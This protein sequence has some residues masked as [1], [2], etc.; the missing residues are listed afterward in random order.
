[1]KLLI[2]TTDTTLQ[3]WGSFKKKMRIVDTAIN[4]GIH[5]DFDS[6][7]VKYVKVTPLVVGGRI[8]HY[9]LEKLKSPYFKQGYDIV[10]LHTSEKQWDDW[11]IQ[12]SL[13]GANPIRKTELGDFYF[14][15][16]EHSLRG[17]LN[18][19]IQVLIHEFRHEYFQQTGLPDDTHKLHGQSND[20]LPHMKTLDWSLYQPVRIGLRNTLNLL[21]KSF[22]ALLKKTVNNLVKTNGISEIH[23]LVK[24][25]SDAIIADMQTLNQPVRL[26]EGYRSPERQTELYN[27]G[28]TTV[29]NKVTNAKAGESL[30]NYGVAVD[31]VFRKEGYNATQEQWELLGQIGKRHGFEWGGDWNGFVDRPHF[32]MTLGYS[33]KSFQQGEVDYSKWA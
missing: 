3:K 25:K 12:S 5:A 17:K 10:G 15:A 16:D 4:S 19:F 11:G 32:E 1:M 2:L 27:Q 33:L 8:D 29:G 6:T 22:I 13:R 24:R 31:F 20:L 26:V 18:R 23:P 14:S 30:H 9:W 21:Q 28:R 7:E